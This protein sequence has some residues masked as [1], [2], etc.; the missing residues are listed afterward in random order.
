MDFELQTIRFD[1]QGV[2]IDFLSL[3]NHLILHANLKDKKKDIRVNIKIISFTIPK[4]TTS[5]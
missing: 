3:V 4:T 5:K 2:F 1:K